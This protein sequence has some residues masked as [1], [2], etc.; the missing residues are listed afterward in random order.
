MPD[1]IS[2]SSALAPQT[3]ACTGAR[4]DYQPG[5]AVDSDDSTAWA[6]ARDDGIGEW[7]ALTFD[8]PVHVLR[9]G[10]VP[11]YAKEGPMKW[12]GCEVRE[13]FW[14]NRWVRRVAY[15]I[16]GESAG[17]AAFR[18][19]PD[20]QWTDVDRIGRTVRA[21]I[22][23]TALPSGEHVDDDT[24]ISEIVIEGRG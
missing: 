1:E 15:E 18:P 24:L 22:V 2:A 7:I 5:N 9:I 14:L 20:L 8:R 21:R 12:A 10:L 6:P 23:D 4:F 17:S 19:A 16:D 13:Q 11:G 3:S